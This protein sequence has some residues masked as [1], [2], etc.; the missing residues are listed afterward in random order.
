[1][2]ACSGKNTGGQPRSN[3]GMSGNGDATIDDPSSRTRRVLIVDDQ[4]ESR[5][6]I[7]R[8]IVSLG[9]EMEIACDGLEALA[10]LRLD[11]DLVVLDATM[12]NLDGFEVAQ[13]IR[14]DPKFL[15]LPIIMLTGLNSK[16]DRLRSI[17]AGVNDFMSKPFEVTELK[18]RS[19]L[20]LKLMMR[21]IRSSATKGN[22]RKPW[23]GGLVTCV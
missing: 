15:S 23:N 10:K 13:R 17:E 20:L 4:E 19:E 7:S 22:W 9:Y 6:T 14:Q 2:I 21:T 16:E 18:L 3:N 12:P 11:V 1:M 8:V 5:Q